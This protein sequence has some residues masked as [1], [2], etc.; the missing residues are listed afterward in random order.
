MEIERVRERE[1]HSDRGI[2][3]ATETEPT[4][5]RLY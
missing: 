5:E 2:D 3:R 4:A 1:P